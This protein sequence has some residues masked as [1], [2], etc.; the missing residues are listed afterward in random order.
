MQF[1]I[2]INQKAFTEVAPECDIIDAA[3][4]DFIHQFI[5]S[6]K[7]E[8]IEDNGD[9]YWVSYQKIIDENPILGIKTKSTIYKRV[10]KLINANILTRYHKNQEMA[11]TYFG[12]GDKYADIIYNKPNSQKNDPSCSKE[13]PPTSEKNDNHSTKDH[14][15]NHIPDSVIEDVYQLYP[16]KVGKK[17]ALKKIRKALEDD[18]SSEELKEKVRLY[19]ESVKDK[20]RQF[21]PYPATWFNQGRYLDDPK[22]WVEYKNEQE[23]SALDEAML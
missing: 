16:R 3:I 15:T 18:I 1:N 8:R 22:E 23:L 14:S 10:E 9:W 4:F 19:A 13:R 6:G 17:K 7:S 11:K 20:N 2:S 21:I 5:G 12:R